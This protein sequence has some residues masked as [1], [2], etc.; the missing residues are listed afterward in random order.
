MANSNMGV[1]FWDTLYVYHQL[2]LPLCFLACTSKF[3]LQIKQMLRDWRTLGTVGPAFT[4]PET[5]ADMERLV[6]EIYLLDTEYSDNKGKK[7]TQ[8]SEAGRVKFL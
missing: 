6:K 8:Q 7:L 2:Q 3:L 5:K 4:T 1:F